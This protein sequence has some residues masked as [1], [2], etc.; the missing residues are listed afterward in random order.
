MQGLVPDSIIDREKS[1]AMPVA[2]W[3]EKDLYDWAKQTLFK[4]NGAGK[5]VKHFAR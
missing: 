1:F 5:T 3:L 4:E 2:H